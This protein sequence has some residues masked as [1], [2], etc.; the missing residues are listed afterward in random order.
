MITAARAFIAALSVGLVSTACS[1][2]K[3][4]DP[5]TQQ[6]SA[7]ATT[8]ASGTA[9]NAATLAAISSAYEVFFAGT[10][11][12]AQSQAVLQHGAR[13]TRTLAEQAKSAYAKKSSAEVDS[14][15]LIA[16]DVAAV[17]FTISSAGSALLNKAPGYAVRTGGKWQVAAQTFCGLLALQGGAPD[18]CND[19][20]VTALPH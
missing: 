19:P 12:T 16:P 11:T 14:A 10:S 2:S 8:A 7:G 13:F 3:T 1:T 18:A 6:A 20:A 4:T 9:A 15:R 17:T 5:A